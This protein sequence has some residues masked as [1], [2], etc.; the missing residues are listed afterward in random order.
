MKSVGIDLVEIK[1]FQKSLKRTADMLE[2]LFTHHELERKAS[3]EN[4]AGWFA[5]KE[6]VMKAIWG[7]KDVKIE[8]HDIVVTH[9]PKGQP[10][11]KLSSDLIE[12]LGDT[13]LKGVSISISHTANI[14]TAFAYISM[15]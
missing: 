1:D 4:L 11:I 14:A 6:A 9:G 3:I 8:W 7:I 10:V 15:E 13:E 5:A 12:R 2:R